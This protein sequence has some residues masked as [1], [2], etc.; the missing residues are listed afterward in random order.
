MK[1]QSKINKDKAT[2]VESQTKNV[3]LE[4]SGVA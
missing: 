4:I 3:E 2:L 1:G